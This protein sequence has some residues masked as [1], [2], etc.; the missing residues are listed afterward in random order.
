MNVDEAFQLLR[1]L[2][3]SPGLVQHHEFV[4]ETANALL[5]GFLRQ[6][7]ALTLDVD[8]VLCG[9]A[10]HDVGRIRV[11]EPNQDASGVGEAMLLTAGVP[12]EIAASCTARSQLSESTPLEALLVALA[13]A[14]STGQRDKLV[15]QVFADRLAALAHGDPQDVWV[16]ADALLA[17]VARDGSR[18]LAQLRG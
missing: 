9:A 6:H 1:G 17:Q 3:A 12:P 7:P 5:A 18:R 8:R 4:V 10:L 11:S 15:E 13:R 16:A 14:L 2:G